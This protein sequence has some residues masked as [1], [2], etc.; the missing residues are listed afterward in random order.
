MEIP[1]PSSRWYEMVY[2]SKSKE[3]E[4]NER[5]GL[6][7]TNAKLGKRLL[8]HLPPRRPLGAVAQPRSTHLRFYL[9]SI[10]GCFRVL[11]G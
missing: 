9:V 8:R 11:S 2:T 3:A 10:F 7:L 4:L 5:S 1:K 6:I